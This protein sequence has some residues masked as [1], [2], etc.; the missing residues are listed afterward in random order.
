MQPNFGLKYLPVLI[1]VK[2]GMSRKETFSTDLM[3]ESKT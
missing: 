3:S 1:L 2:L